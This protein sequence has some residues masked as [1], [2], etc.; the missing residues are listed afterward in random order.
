MSDDQGKVLYHGYLIFDGAQM[1]A[2]KA[3]F[4]E[5][6]FSLISAWRKVEESE[7]DEVQVNTANM[8]RLK[9]DI[10]MLGHSPLPVSG[11]GRAVKRKYWGL[12]EAQRAKI[13]KEELYHEA[14]F[15]LVVDA[16]TIKTKEIQLTR[17][18]GD[19]EYLGIKYDQGYVIHWSGT[20]PFL[21][22]WSVAILA[23][24]EEGL[25]KA[26][27]DFPQTEIDWDKL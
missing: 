1:E 5:K 8:E 10:K 2:V 20:L 19:M 6:D 14:P 27:K 15:F 22:E 13:P 23:H 24:V 9:A 11:F 17:F 3:R 18:R 4:L 26:C 16:A 21:P 12:S 25:R 7:G